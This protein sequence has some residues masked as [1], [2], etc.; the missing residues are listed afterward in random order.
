MPTLAPVVLEGDLETLPPEI[1]WDDALGRLLSLSPELGTAQANVGRAE[2][3][4]VRARLEPI[5]NVRLQGGPMQDMG[6]GGK[7]DGIV[8][9]LLPMPFINR[10]QGGIAQARADLTAAQRAIEQVELDLQNRLA[11]VYE[12][13]ASAVYRVR[14]FRESILPA[15]VDQLDLVRR[16]YAAG[17][18]PFINL[19]NAQR[20]FF[21]Q[22]QQYLQALLDLRSATAEIEGLL[23]RGSLSATP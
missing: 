7:T 4:L 22:N 12:R 8:Q 16:G 1:T 11:P 13:Y 9:V 20:T 21:Q 2:A 23:L 15:A 18:F 19:L 17:E 6:Y 14:M 3:A 5:P 10:N